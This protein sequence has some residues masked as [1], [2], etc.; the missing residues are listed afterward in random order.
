MRNSF[1]NAHPFSKLIYSLFIIFLSFLIVIILGI[2]IAIPVFHITIFEIQDALTDLTKPE[3]LVFLKYLQT[4]QSI[5][6]FIIPAFI[7]AYIFDNSSLSYLAFNKDINFRYLFI[8]AVI[9]LCSLPLINFLA[10]LNSDMQFPDFLRQVELWMKEKEL[11]A[12]EITEAFLKMDSIGSLLFTIFMIGVLPAI[13][14]ELIF[15]GILQ[16]IFT[17]WTKNIHWGIMIAALLFSGMHMQFYGFLPRFILG[18]LFGYLFYW[19]GSIWV[20][21]TAHFVNNTTAV[22]LYYF[23]SDKMSEQI[24]NFGVSEGTY[25]FLLVS[26]FIV[27]YLLWGFYK[28]NKKITGELSG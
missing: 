20:P 5:G 1:G 26:V 3:N 19:S 10:K 25:L 12:Q 18:V 15:R 16:R 9:M 24:D 17:E 13:G 14:E 6:L 4:L 11:A 8:V 7:I 23:F 21:I 28:K 27:S 2:I 22:I